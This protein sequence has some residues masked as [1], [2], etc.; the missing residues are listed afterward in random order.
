MEL[1]KFLWVIGAIGFFAALFLFTPY[2]AYLEGILAFGIV[3]AAALGFL[4]H[5]RREVFY[6]RTTVRLVDPDRNQTLEQ[7]FLAVR[8]ELT[9][10]WLLFV[11]TF[12][13]AAILVFF[14]AGGP[15]QFSYLNWIFSSRY[16]SIL[17][18][19]L[20]F[21]QYPPLLVLILL[22][23]WIGERRVMRDAEACSAESFTIFP[24]HVWWVGRVS[25]AFRGEHGEYYGG[26][27]SYFAF[28]HPRELAS[29]VFHNVRKP[30]LNKI[31]MG[32]LFCRFIILGRGVTD[33][34]EQTAAAQAVL[35]GT[36][37]AS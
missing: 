5:P 3:A 32:F 27:C 31:A 35:A 21:C 4:M 10:L 26:D 2:E 13:A 28:P 29:V 23:A 8:A 33:I 19:G 37:S 1:S 20:A 25:Y 14:A 11:P 18:G 24:A 15:T 6:V 17:I 16:S 9:R 12:L 36:T 22:S 34:D 7:D 30:D